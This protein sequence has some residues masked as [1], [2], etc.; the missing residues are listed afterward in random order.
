[1]YLIFWF[2]NGKQKK[3]SEYQQKVINFVQ[4]LQKNVAHLERRTVQITRLAGKFSSSRVIKKLKP[5]KALRTSAAKILR[6]T[7]RNPAT[8]FL[9]AAIANMIP[10]LDLF[11]WQIIGVWLSYRDERETYADAAKVADDLLEEA[12]AQA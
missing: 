9:G 3:A 10:L 4:D 11:P 8:K 2:T 6:V 1:M 7:R 5:I 12:P